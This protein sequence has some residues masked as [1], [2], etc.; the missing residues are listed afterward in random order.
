MVGIS[1]FGTVTS[2]CKVSTSG[3]TF[4]LELED[5]TGVVLMKLIFIGPWYRLLYLSDGLSI[6]FLRHAFLYLKS[7]ACLTDKSNVS[8]F[9]F[10]MLN[11]MCLMCK[12]PFFLAMV[13]LTC[14][15]SLDEFKC[16]ILNS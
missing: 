5:T 6:Y 16:E 11:R 10:V 3:T 15:S 14:L 8:L 4:Y 7:H 2:V 12:N 13:R 1:L 9:L